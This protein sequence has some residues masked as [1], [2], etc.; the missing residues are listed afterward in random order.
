MRSL[1][2]LAGL[3]VA[4][5]AGCGSGDKPAAK[6]PVKLSQADQGRVITL[7]RG[8]RA[9]VRL[10]QPEWAF[11]PVT[12]GAVR[13]VASPQLVFVHKGCKRFPACG[14][15]TLTV[16]A[17]ARGRSTITALRGSCGELFRCPPSKRKF[18]VTVVVQ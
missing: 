11:Q 12:G 1:W 16:R 17:V 2:L 5:P 15:V 10:D 6:P 7:A 4:L 3:A 18:S 9:V 14:Y 8:R 13:A